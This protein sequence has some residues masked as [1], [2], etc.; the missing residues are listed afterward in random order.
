MVPLFLVYVFPVNFEHVKLSFHPAQ[1]LQVPLD[2]LFDAD[3]KCNLWFPSKFFDLCA[4][5]RISEIMAG[6]VFN[7]PDQSEWFS[8]K[9]Q[10]GFN[11][12]NIFPLEIGANVVG[13]SLPPARQNCP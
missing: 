5:D 1:M 3:G 12:G 6:T 13:L 4:A 9:G 8:Q 7:E 2:G 11:R 10:Y